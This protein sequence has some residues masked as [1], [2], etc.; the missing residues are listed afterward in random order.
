MGEKLVETKY[1]QPAMFI[2]GLAGLEK[3]RIEKP[4]RVE[5]AAVMAGLSLGEYTALCAAGV[6]S[7]EDGLK[8]VKLRGEAMQEAAENGGKQLM[9]SVAGLDGDKLTQLCVEA[10]KEEGASATCAIANALFPN[11]YS[12]GGTEKAINLLKDKA[13]K[14]GALQAKILKTGGAFHTALM[15]PAQTKLNEALEQTRSKMSPPTC[16]IYMNATAELIPAGAPVDKI[17]VNLQKQLTSSVLWEPSMIALIKAGC[18][19]YYECGPMKQ[20][21]AMMK[22]I[23]QKIWKTTENVDV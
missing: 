11:G 7:F 9:L 18:T 20:L 16:N 8:L 6:L 10:K 2:G 12:C 17:V 14:A 23:D 5:R 21:K 3:L 15:Q 22:R 13:E 4:D 19:Q 1:C